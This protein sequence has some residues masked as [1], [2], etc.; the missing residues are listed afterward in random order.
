MAV[1]SISTVALSL[2]ILGAFAL[3]ALGSHRFVE[4]QLAAFEIRVFVPRTATEAEAQQVRDTI[5]KLSLVKNVELLSRDEEYAEFKRKL[6]ADVV[7]G[8]ISNPLPYALKV[9]SKN[10]RQTEV[11]AEQI[12]KIPNVRKV[13]DGKEDHQR[14]RVIADLVRTLGILVAII[15]FL[16]TVFI[17]HNAIRLTLFARRHEIRIMQ[18]VGASNWFIR[19]PLVIEGIVIGTIGALI[20]VGL[21]TLCSGY[22][23]CMVERVLPTLRDLS[24]GLGKVQ[25]LQYMVIAGAAIGA[26]GS[27]ISMRRFLRA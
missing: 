3:L 4:R 21:I 1:A 16:T 23:G 6:N 11:L 15:L 25:L 24:S 12:R 19:A 26:I 7:S 10:S 17:I 18:L 5:A 22:I 20:S 14:L 27:Y 9:E 13:S 2:A 8:I